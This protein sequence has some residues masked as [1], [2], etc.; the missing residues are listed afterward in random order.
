MANDLFQINDFN[1]LRMQKAAMATAALQLKSRQYF[2]P[3]LA[4]TV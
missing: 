3:S 1:H 4:L 2:F